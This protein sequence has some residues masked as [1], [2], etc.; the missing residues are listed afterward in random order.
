[1]DKQFMDK[2]WLAFVGQIAYWGPR[3]W[4]LQF[5]VRGRSFVKWKARPKQLF[6]LNIC[7]MSAYEA[8]QWKKAYT[9]I[10]WWDELRLFGA[11]SK[12]KKGEG[13]LAW[14]STLCRPLC[15]ICHHQRRDLEWELRQTRMN[16]FFNPRSSAILHQEF[17]GLEASTLSISLPVMLENIP[18]S[19]LRDETW[20]I[21]V[22]IGS[23]SN[24]KNVSDT[25][26]SYKLYKIRL[27][28]VKKS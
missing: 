4:G 8:Y 13:E 16:S 18:K 2:S 26:K 5:L 6:W 7:L 20:K 21:S 10:D 1:M 15:T 22:G 28:C 25:R 3:V 27:T 24:K 23:C 11:M 14:K 12:R 19:E 17:H 9:S